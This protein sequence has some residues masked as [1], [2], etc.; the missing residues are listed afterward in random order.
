MKFF[1]SCLFIILFGVIQSHANATDIIDIS[2][3]GSASGPLNGKPGYTDDSVNWVASSGITEGGSFDGVVDDG[4]SSGT[5]TLA[6]TPVP[7]RKYTL[8]GTFNITSGGSDWLG[9]GFVKG[10]SES[11]A[12]TDNR[13]LGDETTGIAWFLLRRNNT[14]RQGIVGD[15]S[16]PDNPNPGLG[17]PDYIDR[18][19]WSSGPSAGDQIDLRIVLDAS[20][21]NSNLWTA[22]WSAKNHDDEN[23]IEVVS[24][25]TLHSADD[26]DAVGFAVGDGSV[27]GS[28]LSFSLSSSTVPELNSYALIL[29]CFSLICV[30]L[31]RHCKF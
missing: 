31:R 30:T 12:K 1:K 3:D 11:S 7:G 27:D 15:T 10:Q 9:F 8:D 16:D 4:F 22:T 17:G 20:E 25:K 6:F 24:R 29:A 5:A 2:F 26:I 23:Y 19:N 21:S 13:F 28:V 18:H 14:L